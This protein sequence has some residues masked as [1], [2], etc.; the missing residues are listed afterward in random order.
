VS[1]RYWVSFWSA[2]PSKWEYHGPWW[3]TGYR[4]VEDSQQESICAAVVADNDDHARRI[5][6]DAHDKGHA[7]VEWRFI[8]ENEPTW[9]PFMAV[10]RVEPRRIRAAVGA[11]RPMKSLA[12]FPEPPRFDVESEHGTDIDAG[13][14]RCKL[15]EGVKSPC[16]PPE[17]EPGGLLVVNDQPGRDE[18]LRGRPLVGQTG[19]YLRRVLARC[20][21]GPLALDNGVKCAPGAR[22]VSDKELSACR[23]YLA[24][25]IREVKPTRILALGT[26]ATHALLG[27]GISPQQTRR[28][29][30]W[31]SSLKGLPPVPVFAVLHPLTAARNRF[32][33]AHFEEDIAWA[34]STPIDPP[35]WKVPRAHL[36]ATEADARAAVAAFREYA[37]AAWDVETAGVMFDPS[38]RILSVAV[39]GRSASHVYVWTAE[40]LANPGAR[41]VLLAWL[42]DPSAAKVGQNEKYDRTALRAAFGVWPHGGVGDTRLW[43]KLLEPEANGALGAMADL[44]GL[45]GHKGEAEAAIEDALA[46]VRRVLAAEKQEAKTRNLSFSFVQPVAI[47]PD[48]A[49]ESVIRE[50]PSEWGRYVYGLI[51]ATT[52]YR[53]NARDSY[54][55]AKLGMMLEADLSTETDLQRTWDVLVGPAAQAVAEVEAWGVPTSRDA[56]E[57]FDAHLSAQLAEIQQR[58]AP[59]GAVNWDSPMQ[60]GELLYKTLGLP[61]LDKTET[62]QPSTSEAT[63]DKLRGHH[64]LP[65]LLLDH[66]GFA[67]MR[68][69]FARGMLAHIRSDG[70]IHPNLKL[71]GARSG[72]MSCE[73]P[74]LQQIPRADSP[75]GKM[76]R[77]VFR[78]E[79]GHTLIQLD[80]SQLELRVAAS[81]S[82]DP[83]MLQIFADG[84]DYHQRT[85]ELVAKTAWGL[86]PSQVT[87]KERSAA[88]IINFGLL[89]GMGDATLAVKIGVSVRDATRM[90]EAILGQFKQLA[91]WCEKLVVDVRRTGLI[92]TEWDGRAARRRPMWRIA[93]ADEQTRK[94]AENGAVNTP[95]QGTASDYGLASLAATVRWIHEDAVPAKLVLP[96]HDALLLEVRDD[97]VDEV[98]FGVR[99]I[100]TSWPSRCALEVDVE[101]GPSWGSLVKYRAP[102]KS[103]AV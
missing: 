40:G 32:L 93:D 55:T 22:K 94:T 78:A 48:A 69:S 99:R 44:I 35:D 89:Y 28:G 36:V 90:R 76:A 88:K 64:P 85:A 50:D 57:A 21:E 102:D 75:E 16:M 98:A 34:C 83:D 2:D 25:V 86:D 5:I 66:R 43:R 97:A 39:C 17:G 23:T 24:Q 10:A 65:G 15:H 91:R 6:E 72:R 42:S 70:R 84:A 9:S 31:L 63:L 77:D 20:W 29:F 8:T 71:D 103:P 11:E 79:P 96:I 30:A 12:L 27:R 68:G 3:V 1:T 58:L 38:F 49:L 60:V 47:A 7:P 82:G 52:L 14:M 33:R 61:V 80:Y 19:T 51:P 100:M 92:W 45:G 101:T 73:A 59:Y 26:G 67:K 54:V 95:V 53:Y 87:K 13:C 37:W 56:L 62:G 18:D 81:L 46:K 4:D 41:A 74:N